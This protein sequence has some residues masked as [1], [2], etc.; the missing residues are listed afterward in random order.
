MSTRRPAARARVTAAATVV[1]AAALTGAA[2]GSPAAAQAGPTTPL[3]VPSRPTAATCPATSGLPLYASPRPAAS[4]TVALTFDDGPSARTTPQILAVLRRNHVHAT[5]F[6]VGTQAQR[7]PA[8]L[9]RIVAE[10]HLVGNHSWSHPLPHGAG[11]FDALPPARI[12]SEID[13]TSRLVTS[14]TGT[15]P[16]L[17]RAPGGYDT[18]AR[19]RSAATKRRL[20]VVDWTYD[21]RDWAAPGSASPAYQRQIV[22]RATGTARHPIVLMHDGPDGAYR[23][24]TVASLQRVIT[25]YKARGY[26]FTDPLGRR[27]PTRR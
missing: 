18:G 21:P 12:A 26:V 7:N 1:L 15:R 5:F 20:T 27:F 22:D 17:L 19:V 14:V 8:L 3:P 23:G 24:N 6:V 9:K 4:R 16:C 25:Y 11:A 2:G 13:R 10:G